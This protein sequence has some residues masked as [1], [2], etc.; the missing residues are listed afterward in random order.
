[1][2]KFKTVFLV[3]LLC[4]F[5]LTGCVRFDTSIK[6]KKNG[7]MDVSMLYAMMDMEDYGYS[8]DELMTEDERQD[9][10]DEGW[11]VEEYSEDGYAGY[12]VSKENLSPD[13]L[14]DELDDMDMDEVSGGSGNFTIKRDGAK[15]IF[16]LNIFDE[17]DAQEMISYGSYIKSS[18]GYMTITISLPVSP[19]A[20]NATKVSED[21]KTLTWDLFEL[22]P[23]EPI[24]VEYS[25]FSIIPILILCGI[26]VILIAIILVVVLIVLGNKKKKAQMQNG[27]YYQNPNMPQG[28]YNP[29]YGQG[30][31]FGQPPYGQAGQPQQ[32]YGQ[33]QQPYGQPQ[34]PGQYQQP[35]GQPGQPQ[36]QAQ[37]QQTPQYQQPVV[38]PAPEAQQPEPT[39]SVVQQPVTE[40]PKTQAEQPFKDTE[41]PKLGE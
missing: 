38:Q 33:P 13:E 3:S 15:Y 17:S 14:S 12:L 8:N 10:I 35:Y 32:P 1:M 4:I 11:T 31:Q 27:G 20:H 16:D 28:Q 30:Q 25:L 39:A 7:K 41:T 36:Y 29:Q 6:V 26:I 2:R 23:G 9:L 21:G 19:S 24:H 37:T 22:E 34:Q 18:G 40:A 5:A